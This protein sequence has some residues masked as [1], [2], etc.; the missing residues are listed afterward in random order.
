MS[1]LQ[2]LSSSSKRE[3]D[4]STAKALDSKTSKYKLANFPSTGTGLTATD[5]AIFSPPTQL[6]LLFRYCVLSCL[7]ENMI[8][9]LPL[10]DYCRKKGS[11]SE[12]AKRFNVYS[13]SK[14]V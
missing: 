7:F 10:V 9:S 12:F 6:Y 1:W 5:S 13:V 8:W 11:Q 3:P 14:L 4:F 2:T